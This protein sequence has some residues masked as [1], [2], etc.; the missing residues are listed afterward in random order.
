MWVRLSC[1]CFK[2]YSLIAKLPKYTKEN[3][4]NGRIVDKV[5]FE[6][7]LLVLLEMEELEAC[8]ALIKAYKN[9]FPEAASRPNLKLV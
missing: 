3:A 5:D 8:E 1:I 7:I 6:A 2:D 4:M 9:I